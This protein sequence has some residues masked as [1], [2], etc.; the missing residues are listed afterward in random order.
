MPLFALTAS[1]KNQ[2]ADIT[3]ADGNGFRELTVRLK[4]AYLK[5][6]VS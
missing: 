1:A 6:S 5:R 3:Q 2:R 4:E